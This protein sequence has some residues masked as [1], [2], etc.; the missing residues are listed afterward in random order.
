MVIVVPVALIAAAAVTTLVMFIDPGGDAKTR[1]EL[2][3][4]GL[5]IGAG[6]GGVVAL[7]LTGRRQ[8]STEH[9]NAERRLTELYVKAVEQLGS[10]KP[11]I[12][13]GGLYALEHVAQDNPDHRARSWS[14]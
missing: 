3:K 6:T 11:A 2:I 4:V 8:W 5:T 12:R 7:V 14:T 9:D 13:H 10:A 1:I